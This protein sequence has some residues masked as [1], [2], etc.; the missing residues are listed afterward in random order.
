MRINKKTL[1]STIRLLMFT[2]WVDRDNGDWNYPFV[3]SV[4]DRIIPDLNDNAT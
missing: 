3:P 4:P 1:E 2:G